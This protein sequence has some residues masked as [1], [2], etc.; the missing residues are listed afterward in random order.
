MDHIYQL[1]SGVARKGSSDG[2]P[3]KCGIRVTMMRLQATRGR[4]HGVYHGPTGIQVVLVQENIFFYV[5]W[6]RS[7]GGYLQGVI[8]YAFD[9][10]LKG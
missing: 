6:M 8:P 5:S 2:P 7:E 9:D 10:V 4:I 3:H 1:A